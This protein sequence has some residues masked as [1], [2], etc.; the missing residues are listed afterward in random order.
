MRAVGNDAQV[1]A[2]IV[3]GAAFLPEGRCVARMT[4]LTLFLHELK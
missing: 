1:S 3:K 4:A 2:W